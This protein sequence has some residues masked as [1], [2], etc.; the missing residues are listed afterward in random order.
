MYYK[1]YGIV[2]IILLI[3]I[4]SSAF[5]YVKKYSIDDNKY[6]FLTYSIILYSFIPIVLYFI[7]KNNGTLVITN[8]VWNIASIIYGIFI[9]VVL[10]NENISDKQ[11][12]GAMLGFFGL[13]LMLYYDN[14]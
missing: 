1:I 4:E 5:Y 11:K 3:I 2:L 13:I 12:I 8:I 6:L 9:G 7:F 10:F 14:K